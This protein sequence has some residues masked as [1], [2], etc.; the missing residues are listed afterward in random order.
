MAEAAAS[1]AASSGRWVGRG[2]KRVED[3]RFVT[4]RGRYVDDVQL[5]GTVHIAVVRSPHA[6]ARILGIDARRA[7]EHPGGVAVVTQADLVHV[8]VMRSDAMEAE[9]CRTSEWTVLADGIVR[10]P[11]EAVAAVVAVDRYVAPA[12]PAFTSAGPTTC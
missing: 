8:K 4:G 1:A 7:R 12:R 2:I 5:P 10:Y 3:E 6:H 9:V 11:G